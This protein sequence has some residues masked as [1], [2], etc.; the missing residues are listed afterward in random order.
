MSGTLTSDSQDK[1]FE[2]SSAETAAPEMLIIL[3]YDGAIRFLQQGRLALEQKNQELADKWLEKLLDI[4][5]ELNVSLDMSQGEISQNLR[6]LY[7][8]YQQEVILA[9]VE[10]NVDRLQAVEDFL[11][12]FRETWTEAARINR[13]PMDMEMDKI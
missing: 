5:V 10:R 9:K 8:F 1:P 3:L 11:K 7:E 2:L 13:N 12:S 4:L 6:R